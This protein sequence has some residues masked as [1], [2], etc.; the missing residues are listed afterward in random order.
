ME[1]L[2]GEIRRELDRFGAPGNIAAVTEA[3]PDAVG[4]EIARNAWPARIARDATLHVATS[5]A[6]WGFEL[7]QLAGEILPRL[8]AA[9]GEAAPKRLKFAPGPLPEPQPDPARPPARPTERDL[10]E[11]A[12]LTAGATDPDLRDVLL[13]AAAASL[14]RARHGEPDDRR[15]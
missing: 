8:R 12:E 6:A 5:S 9:V 4:P 3:W 13:R 2:E 14:P 10:R 11:A 1:R 7:T 15:I